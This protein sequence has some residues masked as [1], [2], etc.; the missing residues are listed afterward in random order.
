MCLCSIAH[1][2]SELGDEVSLCVL[3]DG[4]TVSQAYNDLLLET[5]INAKLTV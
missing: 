2:R 1:M 5:Y 3:A 4:C